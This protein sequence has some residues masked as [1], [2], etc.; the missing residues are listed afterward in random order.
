MALIE[1]LEE[2]KTAD[3]CK[4]LD[5]CEGERYYITTNISVDLGL[6]NG[7]EIELIS[8]CY[9]GKTTMN[10]GKIYFEQIPK[11]LLVRLIRK[12]NDIQSNTFDGL[13]NNLLPIFPIDK[14]FTFKPLH[15]TKSMTIQRKQFPLTPC[16]SFTGFKAQGKTL[17]KIIVDLVKP[18]YGPLTKSFAYVALSRCQKLDD[19]LIL[20]DFDISILQQPVPL[21]LQYEMKRLELLEAQTINEIDMSTYKH[22]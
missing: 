19:L 16:Y 9:E 3:L 18:E 13:D 22:F 1:K 12:N 6:L 17:N 4:N 14:T 20:R 10:D 21:D 5:L 7:A 2:S 15:L 8:I 11:Y